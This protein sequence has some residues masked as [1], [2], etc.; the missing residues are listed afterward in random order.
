[1]GE[2]YSIAVCIKYLINSLVDYLATM[3]IRLYFSLILV[4]VAIP[5]AV[6]EVDMNI[7]NAFVYGDSLLSLS[8][9]NQ[10]EDEWMNTFDFDACTFSTHG[11]NEY[12]I[13]EPGYKAILESNDKSHNSQLLITVLNE[14]KVVNGI[15]TR[16]VEEKET[17]DG[18]LKEISR[19][20]FA[21]CN[22]TSDVFYF[23]EDVDMY[24]NGAVTNREGS[25]L[26]GIE[27]SKAGLIM[28]GDP[29][30]G[31]KYYQEMAPGVA[32]DRA[33][34]LSID[35]SISTPLGEYDKVLKIEESNPL[36]PGIKELKYY[37]P[38]VGLIQDKELILVN[39]TGVE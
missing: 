31:M 13:L 8:L 19:N 25:W 37:A 35:D 30:V 33:E 10:S 27:E 20:Y 24:E 14:T 22:P 23:G 4:I 17:E 1:M 39:Y 26:A 38:Q 6:K 12:F 34:V 29:Q 5:I 2:N 36:E 32:Q 18:D 15:E 7:A 28:P 21:I 16:I 9:E 3:K 11:S